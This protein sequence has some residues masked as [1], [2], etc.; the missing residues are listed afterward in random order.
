[1][2]D[3]VLERIRTLSFDRNALYRQAERTGSGNNNPATL[4]QVKG[5]IVNCTS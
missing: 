5:P 1:M 4:V 3:D 2:N